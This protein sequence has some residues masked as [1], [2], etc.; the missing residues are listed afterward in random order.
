[1]VEAAGVEISQC[2][3]WFCEIVRNPASSLTI[4]R[5][6]IFHHSQHRCTNAHENELLFSRCFPLRTEA[7]GCQ[8]NAGF[9]NGERLARA[10]IF[11]KRSFGLMT[12]WVN[13]SVGA[14]DRI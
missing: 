14:S 6:N 12:F 9:E 8:R 4:V 10:E 13:R 11:G 1:M 7:G 5:L 2:F 3:Q